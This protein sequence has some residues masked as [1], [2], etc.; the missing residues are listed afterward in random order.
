[1]QREPAVIDQCFIE[2]RTYSGSCCRTAI[3]DRAEFIR[4]DSK[5]GERLAAMNCVLCFPG[6]G[7][8]GIGGAAMT[9]RECGLCPEIITSGNTNIGVLCLK[10]AKDNGLCKKCG[11]DI[12]LKARRKKR[13]FQLKAALSFPQEGI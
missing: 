8:S 13:P 3:L 9:S 2:T 6:Y 11:A 7:A 1:M 12:D 5:R 10:C 4:T